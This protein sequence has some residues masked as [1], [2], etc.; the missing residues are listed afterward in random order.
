MMFIESYNSLSIFLEGSFTN[1]SKKKINLLFSLL[2]SPP[3]S[4]LAHRSG[5]FQLISVDK[6]HTQ[7]IPDAGS[8]KMKKT[9]SLTLTSSEPARD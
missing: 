3:N 4:N 1:S 9:W 5:L 8:A 6:A 7:Y 2:S